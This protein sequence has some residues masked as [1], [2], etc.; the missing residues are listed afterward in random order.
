MPETSHRLTKAG[1]ER[2]T[3]LRSE[4][5]KLIFAVSVSGSPALPSYSELARYRKQRV[6]G[7]F[8]RNAANNQ[9]TTRTK[10]LWLDRLRNELSASM[11]PPSSGSGSGNMPAGRWNRTGGDVITCHPSAPIFHGAPV[12]IGEIEIEAFRVFGDTDLDRTPP[13]VELCARFQKVER[14]A[15]LSRAVA[16]TQAAVAASR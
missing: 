12:L 16:L 6:Y 13:T 2:L 10:S 1:E 14:R 15:D 11:E 3:S 8:E 5:V 7:P 9:A 4:P